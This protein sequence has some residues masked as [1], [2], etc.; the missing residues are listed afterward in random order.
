MMSIYEE[1]L[2]IDA[3][4]GHWKSDLYVK[5]APEV[6]ELISNYDFKYKINMFTSNIDGQL[7]YDIPFAYDPF[8]LD[9]LD[10]GEKIYD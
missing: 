2:K 1:L 10:R 5:S 3:K 7:W 6:D 4:M 9:P 8:W